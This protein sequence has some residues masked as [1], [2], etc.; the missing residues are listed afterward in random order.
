[1]APGGLAIAL[2]GV[3]VVLMLFTAAFCCS[4]PIC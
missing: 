2:T 3:G 4:S 1:S